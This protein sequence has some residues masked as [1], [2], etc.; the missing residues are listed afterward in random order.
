MPLPRYAGR[1]LI[2]GITAMNILEMKESDMGGSCSN[3]LRARR[4]AFGL[5][6]LANRLR[7]GADRR[8]ARQVFRPARID[9]VVGGFYDIAVRDIVMGISSMCLAR[10]TSFE[11]AHAAIHSGAR[12]RRTQV[13]G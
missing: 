4:C 13:S 9:L 7:R 1:F 5:A 11:P 10:L 6:D 3:H 2:A 12:L 8:W